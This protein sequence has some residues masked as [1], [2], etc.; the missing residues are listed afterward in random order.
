MRKISTGFAA[1]PSTGSPLVT[2]SVDE[3]REFT[4]KL[5]YTATDVVPRI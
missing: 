2:T 3:W 1:D 5:D 4:V